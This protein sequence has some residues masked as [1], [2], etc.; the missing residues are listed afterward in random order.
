MPMPDWTESQKRA[1]EHF[2]G[3]LLVKAGAGS[4]KTTVLAQRCAALVTRQSDPC[5]VDDLLVVTFTEDAAR[6]MRGKIARAIR[7]AAE[8][9]ANSLRLRQQ[10]ALVDQARIS[11][12][13]S[14]CKWL[15]TAYF[16][17]SGLDP[18]FT[19]LNEHEAQLMF[20][21]SLRET[22]AQWLDRRDDDAEKLKRVLD[23]YANGDAGWLDGC[24]RKLRLTF[25][26]LSDLDVW[27]QGLKN[28]APSAGSVAREYGCWFA[29][30][31]TE[32]AQMLADLPPAPA[33]LSASERQMFDWLADTN[34][35]IRSMAAMLAANPEKNWPG[36]QQLTREI[37]ACRPKSV[38]AVD[39][40]AT[41]V[42]ERFYE[43]LKEHW[44]DLSPTLETSLDVLAKREIESHRLTVSLV[45]FVLDV[46]AAYSAVKQARNQLDFSD[47]EQHAY[48]LL[49][50]PESKA[51]G[52]LRRRFKHVMIDEYQD[53]NPLQDALL[54][55]L[56][57]E[58]GSYFTVGDQQQS[59]YGFRGSEP[60]LFQQRARE[61]KQQ[62]AKKV[63]EMADNFRTLPPVLTAINRVCAHLGKQLPDGDFEAMALEPKRGSEKASESSSP[64][65]ELT[66]LYK[67][68]EN[69][70]ESSDGT[71]DI[72]SSDEPSEDPR[73]MELEAFAVARR[74]KQLVEGGLE[75][76]VNGQK[77]L[78]RYGD[79]AI[80]LRS[81]RNKANVYVQQ[82][83]E[84][85]VPA[86]AELRSGYFAAPEIQ[87]A[88]ALLNVLDNPDQ[89]IALAAVLAGPLGRFSHDELALIRA[90]P[91]ARGCSRFYE[92][93]Q[94]IVQHKNDNSA[95]ADLARR[96]E[97]LQRQL[98]HWRQDIKTIGLPA[99][100]ARI[101]D[102]TG[103][104][105]HY[106]G[107]R[108]GTQQMANL[109]M[110]QQ[111][112]QQFA[113]FNNQGLFRFLEF[114]RQLED[115]EG[116][117]GTAAT[118]L[119]GMDAVRVMSIHQSKGL[120]FPVVVVGGL[121]SGPNKQDLQH[122]LLVDRKRGASLRFIDVHLRRKFN[123]LAYEQ[124]REAAFRRLHEEEA[125]LLYVAMTRARDRLL[126]FGSSK[127]AHLDKLSPLAPI[128]WIR[129]ALAAA[130]D[131]GETVRQQELDA[132]EVAC[133]A[134]RATQGDLAATH[135]AG[136]VAGEIARGN[137]AAL[138]SVKLSAA[139]QQACDEIISVAADP[140]RYRVLAGLPAAT[141]VTR[142]KAHSG[143]AALPAEAAASEVDDALRVPQGEDDDNPA[144]ETSGLMS[145]AG[146]AA[147]ARGLAM[148]R[149]LQYIDLTQTADTL[150]VK[151]QLDQLTSRGILTVQ[152][153]ELVDASAIAWCLQTPIG[154]RLATASVAQGRLFRELPFLWSVPVT[155]LGGELPT[156]LEL[157]DSADR[158]LVRGVIDVLLLEPMPAAN[159]APSTLQGHIIDYK[160]DAPE[161]VQQRLEMYQRQLSY[162][163][164]AVREILH[165]PITAGTLIFL[166]ARQVQSVQV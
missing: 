134:A 93:V 94:A 40:L 63:V 119:E 80:L 33:K 30:K 103:L 57:S 20:S 85:D 38:R 145:K 150:H 65:V 72:D 66:L 29:R 124:I 28:A 47:L 10:A 112:A 105:T 82:L 41:E 73:L 141:S 121:G 3:D 148:H 16:H 32:M 144:V 128:T 163:A 81:V 68:K 156:G 21:Q 58:K 6:E 27:V 120:E 98:D 152:E 18:A 91:A 15:I 77:R 23:Y 61:L 123:P 154:R 45:T 54:A 142:L 161:Y 92:A 151:A 69:E 101:Y 129:D 136:L 44:K 127:A 5:G 62:S 8:Q 118:A 133:L 155:E 2:S 11:T 48:K 140:Y 88:L 160:T 76:E 166:T 26:T 55:L 70:V 50:K 159:G 116:D 36:M 138:Q 31:L 104:L 147:I 125:R 49:T 158:P 122:D 34:I 113:G 64:L 14:F 132:D 102:Q 164:R 79:C 86:F 78:L 13:H 100:L 24:A 7:A 42:K 56:Q 139:E 146:S 87:H 131:A 22:L 130:A 111:R 96:I 59:I 43:P 99:A 83:I 108:N 35:K 95:W 157:T 143:E 17:E 1:I 39:E 4:G 114:L 52:E 117:L 97:R 60:Q 135:E 46:R 75:I 115:D 74:L 25:D 19:M 67:P 110:L 106:A 89:D 162:Y 107:T 12:I 90:A 126:L 51:L 153:A 109:R 137:L 71:D 84:A 53:T 149:C 37:T 9:S 165:I